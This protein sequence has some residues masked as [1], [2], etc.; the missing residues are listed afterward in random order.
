MKIDPK[1]KKKIERT[2]DSLPYVKWDRFC[3]FSRGEYSFFGWI[4]REQDSYK[5]FVTADFDRNGDNLYYMTSSAK[6]SL[7]LFKR[8]GDGTGHGHRNCKR[9][10]DFFSAKTAIKLAPYKRIANFG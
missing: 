6:Y 8:L 9:V 3:E 7:D 2:L 5:D 1:I 10:E 4:D